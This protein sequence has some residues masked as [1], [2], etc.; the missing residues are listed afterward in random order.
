MTSKSDDELA[1][2]EYYRIPRPITMGKVLVSVEALRGDMSCPIC[3]SILNNTAMT[4]ECSHRFC[5]QCI[6]QSLRMSSN[7]CPTCREK[8]A[9]RRSLREDTRLNSMIATIFGN[10][11]QFEKRE[12]QCINQAK[13]RPPIKAVMDTS[14]AISKKRTISNVTSGAA[15]PIAPPSSTAAPSSSV[16]DAAGQQ[17]PTSS[18]V[19]E[20][21]RKKKKSSPSQTANIGTGEDMLFV[22]RK[23]PMER[24]PP[25][26][27]KEYIKASQRLTVAHM[28]QFLLQQYKLYHASS[29]QDSVPLQIVYH[30]QA[31]GDEHI[32]KD[33]DSLEDVVKRFKNGKRVADLI[34]HYKVSREE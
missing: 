2:Y 15:A 31:S 18:A 10:T 1:P 23:H 17:P 27:K 16:S 9:T 13:S 19:Q 14:A 34:L 29:F 7:D 6:E 30:D 33:E 32:L 26:T 8:V 25:A 21:A 4:L 22:L 28:C 11:E 5:K 20:Q 3:L 12:E 24:F